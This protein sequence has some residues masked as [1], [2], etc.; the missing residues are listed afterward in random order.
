LRS[1]RSRLLLC[2][3]HQQLDELLAVDASICDDIPRLRHARTLPFD[4][5]TATDLTPN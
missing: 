2:I 3:E 1:I 4:V 5:L